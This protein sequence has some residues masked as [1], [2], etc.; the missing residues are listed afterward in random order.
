MLNFNA[1]HTRIQYLRI[2]HLK[3][4]LQWLAAIA[5]SA[6]I[7]GCSEPQLTNSTFKGQ[8]MGTFYD[9]KVAHFP[10]TTSEQSSIHAEID[11]LLEQVNEQMSTYRSHS[12]LSRFNLSP[13]VK[14]FPV[15][16][17][18]AKVVAESIRI[19]EITSGAF[20][21]TLGPLVNLWGF[22][23]ENLPQQKP[24]TKMIK[25]AL[26]RVGIQHISNT[27]HTLSKDIDSLYVDLSGIAKG[28]GADVIAEYLTSLGIENYIV[29]LGGDLRARG[30]N[31]N[32]LG[33]QIAIEKAST[34]EHSVQHVVAVGDNAIVTSG[35]YRNYYDLNDERFSHTIDPIT[36][37][38]AQH[39]LVSVTVIHPS[40][41]TADGFATA[42]MAMG[43]EQ[44]M[45]LARQKKL[46]VYMIYKSGDDFKE[47]YTE[48]FSPFFQ[49]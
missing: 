16:E 4:G 45:I 39:N 41:M 2:V 28:Y 21:V 13:A 32:N 43:E 20:D 42:F 36:G 29:G 24:T 15:S 35:S 47:V 5:I 27:K 38:P 10:L 49:K 37:Q 12:E 14:D 25:A 1:I 19:H 8:T 23:P 3:L 9:I 17:D 22:G 48:A 33:W 34:T 31:A 40:A 18:T 46:A 26:S 44:A 30:I 6:T 7:L 11:R